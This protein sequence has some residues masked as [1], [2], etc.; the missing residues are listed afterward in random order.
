MESEQRSSVDGEGSSMLTSWNIEYWNLEESVP[1]EY[2]YSSS[3][4]A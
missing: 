1:T 2:S 4:G 3:D